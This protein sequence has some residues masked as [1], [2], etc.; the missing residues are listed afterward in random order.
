MSSKTPWLKLHSDI[1]FDRKIRRVVKDTGERKA[2]VIGFWS[3]LLV[4]AN[5]SPVRGALYESEGVPLDAE[6]IAFDMDDEIKPVEAMLKAFSAR[7][8]ISTTNNVIH[9]TN[10]GKRQ[11]KTDAQRK[12]EQ[13]ARDKKKPKA[14]DS[15]DAS[16]DV[17]DSHGQSHGVTDCLA[18]DKEREEEI[19]IDKE[20][21]S[22]RDATIQS[23]ERRPDVG[24]VYQALV[25][26]SYQ[27]LRLYLE[28]LNKKERDAIEIIFNDYTPKQL[29]DAHAKLK[30]DTFW[31]TRRISFAK[32]LETM[33][34]MRSV[35]VASTS[36][37]VAL[38]PHCDF[39][40]NQRG[41]VADDRSGIAAYVTCQSDFHTVA[42]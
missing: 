28:N 5:D 15:P 30:S 4:M 36:R 39:P 10:W 31:Q 40:P 22:A 12:A 3:S 26:L 34:A 16:Q 13:R 38:C 29:R 11:S 19:R 37:R 24:N 9:I 2:T 23:F 17:T 14:G 35:T 25:G 33:Q 42:A 20:P 32:L 8:M 18:L 1:L 21:D 41:V 7:G 27:E 6:G